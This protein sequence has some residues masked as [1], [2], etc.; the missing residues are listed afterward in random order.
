M[1]TQKKPI[2]ID[3]NKI[4]KCDCEDKYGPKP[5]TVSNTKQPYNQSK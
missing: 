4:K 2:N 1:N 3:P 5:F